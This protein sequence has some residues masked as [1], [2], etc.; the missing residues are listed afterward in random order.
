MRTFGSAILGLAA[1]LLAA[2]ALCSA[3]LAE[4][5][6]S[7][8][9]FVALGQPL[10]TDEAFQQD[11]SEEVGAQVA[12]SA[13]IP[14]AVA[15]FVQPLITS[16]V[17]GV[18]SL[19]GYPQAWDQTLSRSHAQTFDGEGGVTLDLAP[20]V[21]LVAQELGSGIGVDIPAP[22]QTLIDLGGADQ[23]AEIQRAATA[24]TAWPY[25]A[26]GAGIAA[27]LA[28]LAARRRGTT[29]ALLGAGLLLA[30]GAL[31]LGAA[32][33]PTLAGQP[34]YASG[35]AETFA[36][37]FAAETAASLQAWALVFMLGAAALLVVGLASAWAARRRRA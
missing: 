26:A 22:E 30:G 28:L 12:A 6:V 14:G 17:Q 20:V 11:V 35:L 13:R 4:N 18:Q 15:S 1:V 7:E 2:A 19:P 29:L 3:W 27:V 34:A 32:S 10:G 33:L 9:G 25:L 36:S 24:S 23:R 37:A 21:G 8:S 16:A 5:V 31:W